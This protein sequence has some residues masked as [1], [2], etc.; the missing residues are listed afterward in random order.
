[1]S[2]SELERRKMIYKFC[3]DYPNQKKSEIFRHFSNFGFKRSFVYKTVKAYESGKACERQP[4]S[5]KKCTLQDS[6]TRAR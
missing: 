3:D 1:M 2:L 5:G 6:K 4:G